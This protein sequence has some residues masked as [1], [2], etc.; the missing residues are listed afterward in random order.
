MAQ[1]QAGRRGLQ[2][3]KVIDLRSYR[4][5]APGSEPG[6]RAVLD[7]LPAGT[8]LL[9][10]QYTI[11]DYLNS[12][13]FGITYRA[14][15]SLGRSVV[16]KECFPAIMCIRKG[17]SVVP[18]TA[19]CAEELKK[20]VGQFVTEAHSLAA[21]QHKNIVHVHQ[22]FEENDTAYMAID[23]IDGLD[24]LELT[25]RR[26]EEITPE[27]VVRITKRMLPAIKYIHDSEM[28]HRDIS[29]DNIL[30]DETGE[31]IL[32]DFG[33][34]RKKAK[35]SSRSFSQMKFVK[36]GYSPQ[37]FYIEG[38]EQ[39]PFS[40]LYS[41]AATL[42]HVISG[43]APEDGQRRLSALAQK[44][45]DP[46]R[47]LAGR[48]AG[49]PRG[50]LPAIDDALI[51]VPHKRIQSAE[52]WIARLTSAPKRGHRPKMMPVPK[53]KYAETSNIVASEADVRA[54]LSDK[55][56][57]A[58]KFRKARFFLFGAIALMAG[59]ASVPLFMGA[60][61]GAPGST[62]VAGLSGAS[63]TTPLRSDEVGKDP[64]PS[65]TGADV[66][67]DIEVSHN[68]ASVPHARPSVWSNDAKTLDQVISEIHAK[69]L[70]RARPLAATSDD[71]VTLAL[72]ATFV[73]ESNVEIVLPDSGSP[74]PL[75]S[76]TP[77]GLMRTGPD[78][79]AAVDLA[80]STE[81]ELG[82][83]ENSKLAVSA[84]WRIALP[85]ES[86]PIKAR[87]AHTIEITKILDPEAAARAGDWVMP[88]TVIYAFNGE[89]LEEGKSLSANVLQAV[90]VD[91]D[92][93]T[94]ATVLYK[95]PETGRINRGLL[96]LP[97]QRQIALPDG[98]LLQA[99]VEDRIWV[100]RVVVSGSSGFL[101]GDRLL[102]ESVLDIDIS[103]EIGVETI[104]DGLIAAGASEAVFAVDRDG[105]AQ[106]VSLPIASQNSGMAR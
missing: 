51:I 68:L 50:F 13:G 97:V 105:D 47:P 26:S 54:S 45:P 29:P 100:T 40:D 80:T 78:A 93:V 46:Y 82:S 12:G 43:E 91:P 102:S 34:A 10:G 48:F 61:P 42:Y 2:R 36:D 17:T 8:S 81:P 23:F 32:I 1:W 31:P 71:E 37:E 19:D 44:Q 49:F 14:K 75:R 55:V 35:T 5:D 104:M 59:G 90:K 21:L 16:I 38:A 62:E 60:E 99:Q 67:G 9:R 103:T 84:H 72:P 86:R 18:R 30:I 20:M 11:T 92:G 41:F 39:G 69:R 3:N 63:L 22:V 65:T 73:L 96:M 64:I 57:T 24:L 89:K 88:G 7:D 66:H 98:T 6:S 70:L 101:V 95:V 106:S 76:S 79:S 33:A 15:D 74:E 25:E 77:R 4:G 85:F 52:E 53:P 58:G 94:R 83:I 27:E 56:P 87:N 28:L